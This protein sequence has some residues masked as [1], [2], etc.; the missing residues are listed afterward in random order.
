MS[1]TRGAGPFH[2]HT[3]YTRDGKPVVQVYVPPFEPY[4]EILSWGSRYF[5]WDAERKQYREALCF[6]IPPQLEVERPG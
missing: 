1:Y 2:V 5:V 4:A 6:W 3:L